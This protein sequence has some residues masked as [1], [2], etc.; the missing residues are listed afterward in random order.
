VNRHATPGHAATPPWARFDDLVEGTATVFPAFERELFAMHEED[1]LD[2]IRDVE[3]A[4]AQ[5]NWAVGYIAYEAAASF[6]P[7][8]PA[9]APG[10]VQ[11]SGAQLP[12][13]WFG[14]APSPI[15]STETIVATEPYWTG[16]WRDHWDR[17]SYQRAFNQVRASIA[18]GDTYQCNLTT[19]LTTTF[20][21]DPVSFYSDLARNQM[22]KYSAYLDLGND[23][24]ASASPELFFEWVG[25]VVRTR[26]MKGTAKRG[27]T[28]Q[29]DDQAVRQLLSSSKERAENLIIV[30]LLRNDLGRI[31]STGTVTV[32]A[33]LTPERY[34]T[35]WQLTSDVTARVP[36]DVG[37][38][39][40]L[41]ALFP[42]GSIT[43]AP[44]AK[45]MS[46]ISEL[47]QRRRGVYCGAIGWVAPPT[48][49][50]RARFSVAIRTAHI[51]RARSVCEYGV[52]SGI[53]WGS[54]FAAEHAELG[55]K[56]EILRRR[57]VPFG[58]IETMRVD[59]SGTVHNVEGHLARLTD[60]AL[61]FAITLD[62][63][64]LRTELA[65]TAR[66][67][68]GR[69]VRVEVDQQGATTLTTGPGPR[70][71]SGPLLLEVDGDPIDSSSHWFAH[72]T[73]NR[74]AF[75]ARTR[76]HPAADDVI[77]TNEHGFVTETT[78]ANIALR[79]AGRWYTPPVSD[80]CLPGVERSRLIAAGKLREKSIHLDDLYTAEAIALASS[81]R[82]WRSAVL[83]SDSPQTGVFPL[84]ESKPVLDR[85]G[86]A[87]APHM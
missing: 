36:K 23:V 83:L 13:V 1:V 35:V 4:T 42:C 53:T 66:R 30:D 57:P 61:Y 12:L 21:G 31:A 48:Q 84:N 69:V 72:K 79:I 56:Q 6:D 71:K 47:E 17:E 78:V 26:P 19:V 40:I 63:G 2:V 86:E 82:G 24:I 18:A 45:T 34:S 38:L 73:T 62:T 68:A 29:E 46:I 41:K 22:A 49:P 52:G 10:S 39:E 28:N 3:D 5:G 65:T 14:I 80:G 70:C 55:A 27:R 9:A 25:D 59:A 50:V 43:G 37:L 87:G 32:P 77:L 7:H 85:I 33:L 64:L 11:A 54:D 81:V 74:S 67:Q 44:K 60:S 75:E 76:R 8:L 58:L 15:Q 51:D 16:L 20:S